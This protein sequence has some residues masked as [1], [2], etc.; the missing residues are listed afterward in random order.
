MFKNLRSYVWDSDIPAF[1]SSKRGSTARSKERDYFPRENLLRCVS[2]GAIIRQAL[3]DDGAKLK[4]T[5]RE[6]DYFPRE[7]SWA[8]FQHARLT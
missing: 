2:T 8:V 6:C 4:Q 5:Q 7:N 3:Q 1:A